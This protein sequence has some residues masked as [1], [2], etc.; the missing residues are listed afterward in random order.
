M[1]KGID[2]SKWQGSI[3]FDAV[4]KTQD[5]IIIRSSYGNGYTDEFFTRNRDECRRLDIPHGFYH[6]SYPQYN[7]PEAEADWFLHVVGN[8]ESGESLYLDFE[9]RYPTPV[10]WSK[11]FLDRISEQLEGYKPLIYLNKYTTE[12][13]DWSPIADAGNGLW[14]AYWDYDPN[15]TFNVPHWDIVAMRQFSNNESINGISGRVDGNVFYGD[16]E[17]FMAYGVGEGEIPCKKVILENEQLKSENKHLVEANKGLLESLQDLNALYKKLLEEDEIEDEE[18]EQLLKDYGVLEGLYE[19]QTDRVADLDGKNQIL[20]DKNDELLA[21]NQRLKDQRFT[22]SESIVFVI[23][24]L[25]GG[26]DNA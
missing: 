9:E 20:K 13:Y 18:L 5:F 23:R 22:L 16:L 1:L 6:Y 15:G 12:C 4:A 24:A 17:Q 14:L 11:R 3:D 25:K 10:E 21:E 19:D 26:A 2:I 8:L 7:E